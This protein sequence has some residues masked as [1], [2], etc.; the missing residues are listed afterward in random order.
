MRSCIFN[1]NVGDGV[2]SEGAIAVNWFSCD[3]SQTTASAKANTGNGVR[4]SNNTAGNGPYTFTGCWF[5]NNKSNGI[6]V[7]VNSTVN[8]VGCYF[9]GYSG[10]GSQQW[11][12]SCG[13]QTSI[14]GC[15]FAGHYLGSIDNRYGSPLFWSPTSCTDATFVKLNNG[16]NI[17]L[18]AAQGGGTI[19]YSNI[20]GRSFQTL[21]AN[22]AV[23]IN[24]TLGETF[25]ITLAANATSSTISNPGGQGQRL[26]I[27]WIQ[28]AT[29]LR[30][31][32]WPTNCRFAGNAAP[33][34]TTTAGYK[35]SVTFEFN[36][37]VWTEIGRAI[38]VPN[39]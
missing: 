10:S 27:E 22:G 21:G 25:E 20:R 38:G 5:E 9:V 7:A 31:Y 28:D 36:G 19:G 14:L 3:F 32:V 30:T 17:P 8:C 11:G 23:T 1:Y 13:A 35:D 26:T 4:I 2:Y 33:T 29:G 18:A 15:V 12:L 34:A 37:T 6:S 16:G 39:S 24:A